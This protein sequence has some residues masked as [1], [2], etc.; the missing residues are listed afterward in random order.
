VEKSETGCG[1]N[2]M[3]STAPDALMARVVVTRLPKAK[4]A[5]N[6][7]TESKVAHGSYAAQITN[8][9]PANTANSCRRRIRRRSRAP[10]YSSRGEATSNTMKAR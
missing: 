5:A 7:S 3:S 1:G 10:K 9:L 8:T 2:R 6:T 4:D